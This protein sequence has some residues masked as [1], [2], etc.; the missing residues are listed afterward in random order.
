LD[1]ACASAVETGDLLELC[2]QMELLGPVV[3]NLTLG[4]CHRSQQ[5]IRGLINRLRRG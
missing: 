2:G 4:R 1:I 3:T 5:L